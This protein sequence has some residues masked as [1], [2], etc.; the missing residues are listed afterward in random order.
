MFGSETRVMTLR[1]GRN[2]RIFYKQC[3][4][5]YRGNETEAV[6]GGAMAIPISGQING[7]CG[8]RGGRYIC[9]PISLKNKKI[10]S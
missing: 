3:G 9:F 4:P 5:P 1:V 2:L 6:H 8:D 7:G 10:R